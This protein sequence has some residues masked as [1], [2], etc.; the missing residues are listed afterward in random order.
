MISFLYKST[1]CFDK[2]DELKKPVFKEV[3]LH[4]SFVVQNNTARDPHTR[5]KTHKQFLSVFCDLFKAAI[6]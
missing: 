3:V 2:I 4:F 6:L 5:L 1:K